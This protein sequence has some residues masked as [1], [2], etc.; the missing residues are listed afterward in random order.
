MN[1]RWMA[2]CLALLTLAL[3][4][5][6]RERAHAQSKEL[7]AEELTDRAELVAVGKVNALRSEWNT[8]R[9]RIVTHVTVAVDQ[10]LKGEQPRRSLVITVPGG[11]VDGV[12][13]L[14]THAARFK[15][16]EDVVVFVERDSR[17]TLRVLGGEQ[18]KFSITKDQHTDKQMVSHQKTLD[19]F[20]TQIRL[21]VQRQG[22][23][24]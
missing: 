15:N 5:G 19:E 7:P 22:E 10:Y 11:E 3:S 21:A 2:G 16:D 23:N 9:T 14:Y 1:K 4:H 17:G 13:E 24:K 20:K 6:I 12:G 8:A 18:G